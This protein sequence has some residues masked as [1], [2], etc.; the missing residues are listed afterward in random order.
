MNKCSKILPAGS[1]DPR[2]AATS[3]AA[4]YEGRFRRRLMLRLENGEEILLDLEKPSL[5]REGD[6]L[7]LDCGRIVAV[8]ALSEDLMEVRAQTVEGLIRLAWHIG[9][10]HLA[11]MIREDCIVIRNDPVIAAMIKGLGGHLTAVKAGFN[12]ENGAYASREESDHG[13]GHHHVHAHGHA[14]HH[15]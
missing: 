13:G 12:S 3:Y 8:R 5:L 7:Q 15:D 1:W 6:G 9:N 14:H 4:D 11:A 10:R 2:Q